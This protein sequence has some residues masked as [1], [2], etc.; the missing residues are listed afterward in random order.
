VQLRIS[1][2][3]V[4]KE[5]RSILSKMNVASR[6]AAAVRAVKTGLLKE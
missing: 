1:T 4:N 3:T 5:V 6:T 2:Y